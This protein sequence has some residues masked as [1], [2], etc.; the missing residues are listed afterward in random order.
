[1]QFPEFPV[2]MGVFRAVE[3]PTYEQMLAGQISAAIEAK[4]AGKV[5]KLLNSG[6]TWYIN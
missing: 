5:E 1:M 6:E 3:K 4:G 2:P